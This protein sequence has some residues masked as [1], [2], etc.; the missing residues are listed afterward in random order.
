MQEA[1]RIIVGGGRTLSYAASVKRRDR[2]HGTVAVPVLDALNW[3]AA[4]ISESGTERRLPLS[5]R[6]SAG[7]RDT[8]DIDAKATCRCPHSIVRDL[9]PP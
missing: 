9:K 6:M 1:Q 4:I 2:S 3:R 7:H 8:A 5:A